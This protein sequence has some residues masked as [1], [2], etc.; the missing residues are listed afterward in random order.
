MDNSAKAVLTNER[1]IAVDQDPLGLQAIKVVEPH[2]G[3]QI[4]VKPLAGTGHRAVLL[5]NRTS[6][7]ATLET[8]WEQIGLDEQSSARVQDLWSGRE[9][10]SSPSGYAASVPAG[11]AVLLKVNG[12]ESR[13]TPYVASTSVNRLHDGDAS[14]QCATCGDGRDAAIGGR[15]SV[16]SDIAPPKGVAVVRVSYVNPGK[17]PLIVQLKVDGKTPTNVLLPPTSRKEQIGSVACEVELTQEG[18]SSTLS[19]SWADAP[20]VKLKSI[21]V[22]TLGEP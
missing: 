2:P 13:S 1:I 20:G 7:E 9:L 8:S 11:D 17:L 6:T 18:P 12:R 4:W 3:L 16:S 22:Q 5:L 14:E 10:E 21:T 15:K 19:F